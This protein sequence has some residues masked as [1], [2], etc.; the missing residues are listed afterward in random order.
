MIW[1]PIRMCATSVLALVLAACSNSYTAT[2]LV[3][4]TTSSLPH[5]N[6]QSVYDA[7]IQAT[8]GGT[9]YEWSISSGTLPPGLTLDEFADGPATSISGVPS[10]SGSFDFV[11]QVLS[12]GSASRQP[13]QLR[14]D[15]ALVG[16][17]TDFPPQPGARIVHVSSSL[18]DDTSPGTEAQ[19]K[20]TLAAGMALIRNGN[21]DWLLLRRGDTWQIPSEFRF[22]R[23][24]PTSGPGWMR[25][26]AYGDLNDPRPVLDAVDRGFVTLTPGFRSSM[27]V[28]NV[29]LTDLHILASNRLANSATATSTNYG[30]NFFA[31]EWQGTGF[32]FSN[33]L[34]ENVR[35]TGFRGGIQSG[36]DCTN[37]AIRRCIFDDIFE[38][39]SG[40]AN[41]ILWTPTN[42]VL[43]DNVF[44]RIQSPD[45][46]GVPANP[47]SSHSVYGVASAVNVRARGNIVIKAYDGM[48]LRHGGDWLRNVSA[49]CQVGGVIG[50][51]WG[52][53]PTPGGVVCNMQ[54][55]LVLNITSLP[56]YLGNTRSG[57]VRRNMFVRDQDGTLN[58]D[59]QMIPANDAGAGRNIGVHATTFADNYLS[60]GI[61]YNPT[62]TSSFSGLVFENNTENQGTTPTGI[63]AYLAAA[64]IQG[65][66]IDDWANH[67]L[68]RDRNNFTETHLSTSVLNFY[69]Q[70]VG[71]PP[72]Q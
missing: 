2:N 30:L 15:L 56:L 65:T 54:D 19:P 14:V 43:E 11:V 36:S 46:P 57:E 8:L 37:L 62:L 7:P 32:A 34:V 22:E 51:A 29:A 67:L 17:W 6:V 1:H 20:R 66:T 48:M 10:A 28:T 53:T 72:L 70:Q 33:I 35:I 42:A 45:T 16:G 58:V 18:G 71:L 5:G 4:I 21:P 40:G 47:V 64:G 3:S 13:F 68:L 50:Q 26:G 52:V 63:G 39:S 55:S 31:V 59:L 69:R 25:F 23:T 27:Q 38:H 12:D 24:G 9:S 41:G 61:L 60:G 49:H 44:Y